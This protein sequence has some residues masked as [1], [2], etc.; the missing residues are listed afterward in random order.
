MREVIWQ[1][2]VSEDVSWQD[3]LQVRIWRIEGIR[4]ELR[5]R[6]LSG[7]LQLRRTLIDGLTGEILDD[8]G[9]DVGAHKL[10][11]P[12]AR[13]LSSRPSTRCPGDAETSRGVA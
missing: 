5:T 6:G 7:L 12:P 9:L 13:P 11:S 2:H 1:R 8:V 4:V 10:D 3:G